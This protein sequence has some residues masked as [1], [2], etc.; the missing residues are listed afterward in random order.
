MSTFTASTTTLFLKRT[1]LSGRATTKPPSAVIMTP[2]LTPLTASSSS[3]SSSPAFG[4]GR[5]TSMRK[6]FGIPVVRLIRGR[7]SYAGSLFVG[8]SW[9]QW[10][11]GRSSLLSAIPLTRQAVNQRSHLSDRT[12]SRCSPREGAC[13]PFRNRGTRAERQRRCYCRV[14]GVG[15]QRSDCGRS[16]WR[17]KKLVRACSERHLNAERAYLAICSCVCCHWVLVAANMA[18]IADA[19]SLGAAAGI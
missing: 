9:I 5:F 3:S 6:L 19:S 17:W 8:H 11:M 2:A 7:L 15:S 18:A 4:A 16:A 10:P 1:Y 13:A 14:A 12:D